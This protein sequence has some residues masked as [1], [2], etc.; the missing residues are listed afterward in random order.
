M[1]L[2]EEDGQED[3]D[4]MWCDH[5]IPIERVAKMRCYQRTS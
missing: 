4:L 1:K 2:V 5:A 3:F